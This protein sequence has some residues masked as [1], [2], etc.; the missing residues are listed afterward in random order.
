[1]HGDEDLARAIG[2]PHEDVHRERVEDLV[3]VEHAFDRPERARVGRPTDVAAVECRGLLGAK[4]LRH[5]DDRRP[6]APRGI[7][8]LTLKRRENI[9]QQRPPPRAS[10][11]E[12]PRV[13][14][15]ELLPEVRHR[16]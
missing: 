15:S 12:I 16:S 9:P 13:R 6:H 2:R 1:M 7:G 8:S 10:L 4:V 3:R 11:D 5:L 14:L